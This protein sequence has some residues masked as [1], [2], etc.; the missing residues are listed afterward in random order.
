MSERKKPTE[1]VETALLFGVLFL[2]SYFAQSSDFDQSILYTNS[3]NISY[4]LTMLPQILLLIFVAT[5][6]GEAELYGIRSVTPRDLVFV[7]L[8]VVA[9][10]VIALPVIA[11][12]GSI[13]RI[14]TRGESPELGFS[15]IVLIVASALATGYR[16]ELFFRSNFYVRIRNHGLKVTAA[17][18]ASSL[19]FAAGHIYQGAA[20]FGGAFAMGL[21]LVFLFE[22]Q[23]K[24]HVI[25][26]GHAGFNTIMLLIALP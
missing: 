7:L 15:A 17:A 12:N 11:A 20:A 26:I 19:L 23:R 6:G 8:T 5:R 3:Y 24:I 14:F 1:L 13:D 9:L 21:F 10:L 22:K 18:L 4:I 25:A 16:E 2:T